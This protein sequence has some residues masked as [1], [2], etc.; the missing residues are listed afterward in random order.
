MERERISFNFKE[1]IK[2][3]FGNGEAYVKDDDIEKEVNE[4]IAK[5]DSDFISK[6]EKA[7][8]STENKSGGKKS[9]SDISNF[10]VAK[11]EETVRNIDD[12]ERDEER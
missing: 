7:V 12:K 11:K 6:L 10:K 2:A 8:I 1:L 3:F 9:K 4:I 5:Q